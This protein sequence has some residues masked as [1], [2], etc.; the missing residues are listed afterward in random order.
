MQFD[1]IL[2]NYNFLIS[3]SNKICYNNSRIKYHSTHHSGGVYGYSTLSV[4]RFADCYVTVDLNRG[5]RPGNPDTYRTTQSPSETA[6]LTLEP[7]LTPIVTLTE[8]PNETPVPTETPIE[9]PIATEIST[10]L[11]EATPPEASATL[12][13]SPTE[14]LPP[15]EPIWTA[16]F[17][18][19][20]NHG[21]L[22]AWTLGNGWTLV[23]DASGGQALLKCSTAVKQPFSIRAASSMPPPRPVLGFNMALL[24]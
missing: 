17:S 12:P 18:D 8:T 11:P 13:A 23:P 5:G 21:D 10:L 1:F 6:T 7:T 2:D 15:P 14:S 16:L 9:L 4:Q 24:S 19:N 20:F 22:S 3:V